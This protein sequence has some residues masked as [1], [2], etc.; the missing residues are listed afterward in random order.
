MN[1][2]QYCKN[3]TD[4]TILRNRKFWLHQILGYHGNTASKKG[5]F[6]STVILLISLC[7]YGKWIIWCSLIYFLHTKWII[8]EHLHHL[9]CGHFITSHHITLNVLSWW[10]GFCIVFPKFVM[11]KFPIHQA[12]QHL[13]VKW[14]L[15]NLILN[16]NLWTKTQKE[17]FSLMSKNWCHMF[18]DHKQKFLK[19]KKNGLF[20]E[21]VKI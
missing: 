15:I 9:V 18:R 6:W 14:L 12:I 17:S 21:G 10:W 5:Q 11:C 16:L 13:A 7:Y 8:S 19:R 3:S 2:I 4:A 20:C 1:K